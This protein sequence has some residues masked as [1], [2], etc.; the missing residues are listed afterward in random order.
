MKTE[1]RL[2]EALKEMMESTPLD[3]ISVVTLTKKCG[4]NRQTFYYHFHDVYDLLTLVFLN[5]R[6]RNIEKA[7]KLNDMVVMIYRYYEDNALFVDATL[8][9]AGKELFQEFVYNNCYQTILR[10]VNEAPNNKKLLTNDR[11]SIARFYAL[12]YAHNIVYYLSVFKNKTLQGLLSCFCFEK[13][14]NLAIAI[15]NFIE[16]K[17]MNG[18]D[19]F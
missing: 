14:E 7:K 15:N 17:G 3:E 12:A 5:E 19:R 9:G 6:I 11:K 18:N 10:F 13:D 8:N 4:I 16:Y 1:Y 2:S